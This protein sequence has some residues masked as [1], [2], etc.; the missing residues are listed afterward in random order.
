MK[1]RSVGGWV[2]LLRGKQMLKITKRSVAPTKV[3]DVAVSGTH[4]FFAND[5][6][7]SDLHVTK[8][9]LKLGLKFKKI[10]H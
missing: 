1:S 6:L 8:K 7:N 9:I 5:N 3:Y 2:E 10:D 4:N